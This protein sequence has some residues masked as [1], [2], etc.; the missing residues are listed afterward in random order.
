M[1][2]VTCTEKSKPAG[3]ERPVP[4]PMLPLRP[5]AVDRMAGLVKL[6]GDLLDA[7]DRVADLIGDPLSAVGSANIKAGEVRD[8]ID[9]AVFLVVDEFECLFQRDPEARAALMRAVSALPADDDGRR[10]D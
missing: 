8:K 1:K 3:R 10:G 4:M 6:A 9:E 5:S 7:R 2:Q